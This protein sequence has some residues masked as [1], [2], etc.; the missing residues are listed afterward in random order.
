MATVNPNAS[1]IWDETEVYVIPANL[2]EDIE[3]LVPTTV[4]ELLDELWDEGFVGLID[5]SAGVPLTPELEI[6]HY[7][8]FGHAR[9]RSKAKKGVVTTGFT[10]FEAN[11]VTR[12]F[13]LPGSRAGKMGAPKS[14]YFYTCYVSRDESPAGTSTR[15]LISSRPALFE[16]SSHAGMVEGEQESYEITVHHANDAEGDVFYVVEGI[17]SDELE[18]T[19][20]TLPAGVVGTPYS[21]TLVATGGEG[22]KT[23]TKTGTLP[24]GLTLSTSGVLSGTPSAAGSP[25][26]TFTVTD[27]AL[28]TDSQVITVT[29]TA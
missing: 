6:T 11:D 18:I 25:S 16:L 1:Y 24:T 19:T 3:D 13:V 21:Q 2:V 27:T 5:A 12:K 29:V 14:Q 4:S 28:A 22:A 8:A 20:T 10:A 17:A 26:I 9:Y 23:W 15:V 7:D